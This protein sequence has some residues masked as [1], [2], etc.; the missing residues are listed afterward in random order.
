M[1][2]EFGT[3]EILENKY[4]KLFLFCSQKSTPAG[5]C[6]EPKKSPMRVSVKLEYQAGLEYVKPVYDHVGGKVD[7]IRG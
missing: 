5:S 1:G 4:R 2:V 7:F 6:Q 3:L